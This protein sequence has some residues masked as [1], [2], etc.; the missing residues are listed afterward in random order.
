[1][2]RREWIWIV[3]WLTGCGRSAVEQGASTSGEAAR[4]PPKI[5]LF[6]ATPDKVEPGGTAKLCYS[7][8]GITQLV[9]TPPV[10]EVWPAYTRCVEVSP[11]R[12][13]IYTLTGES[14]SGEKVTQS[15]TVGMA[16]PKPKLTDLWVSALEIVPPQKSV[17]FCYTVEHSTGILL[18]PIGWTSKKAKDCTLL[19]PTKTTT[20]TITAFSAQRVM[21]KGQFTVRVK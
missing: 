19:S 16:E 12:E 8:E 15:V 9:L 3:V 17:Q 4:I 10:A 13:T 5:A 6:Y 14:A 2:W 21:D 20:Y 1:M 11:K 7:T 18:E